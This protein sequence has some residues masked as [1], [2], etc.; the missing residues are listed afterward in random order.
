[1]YDGPP[2]SANAVAVVATQGT[3]LH[4]VDKRCTD[5]E[6][7]EASTFAVEPGMR[8]LDVSL[9]DGPLR[10]PG[11]RRYSDDWLAICLDAGPGRTYR[12]SP[13]YEGNQWRPVVVDQATSAPVPARVLAPEHPYCYARPAPAMPPVATTTTPDGDGDS[14]SVS[15]SPPQAVPPP[16]RIMGRVRLA[17]PEPPRRTHGNFHL[18]ASTASGGGDLF[19]AFHADTT[20]H[21][22]NAGDGTGVALGVSLT[23]YWAGKVIGLGGDADVGYKLASA[24]GAELSSFPLVLSA[25][26]I[27]AIGESWAVLLRAGAEHDARIKVTPGSGSMTLS[28]ALSSGWGVVGEIGTS[29]TSARGPGVSLAFRVTRINYDI[30]SANSAGVALSLRYDLFDSP[31]ADLTCTR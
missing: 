19:A 26:A 29:F 8:V 20:T 31:P 16:A 14:S 22:L 1:M 6:P 7:E 25:H 30:V 24:P 10:G 2:R 21:R 9:N 13:V 4:R 11:E 5:D 15:R 3:R 17:A 28:G 18:E 23:P 27:L 12:V